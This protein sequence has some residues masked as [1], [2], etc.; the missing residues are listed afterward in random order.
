MR[1]PTVETADVLRRELPE[2]TV[3]FRGREAQLRQA[4]MPMN[5][6][7]LVRLPTSRAPHTHMTP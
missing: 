7:S 1:P 3:E 2:L 6:V 4:K 5:V